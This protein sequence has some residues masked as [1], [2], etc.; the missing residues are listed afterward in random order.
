MFSIS[1]H[2]KKLLESF[3]SLSF[4]NVANSII[5]ILIF[6]YLIRVLG[7]SQ[8]GILMLINS[9]VIYS[10]TIVDYGFNLLGTS[11]ISKNRE[12]RYK[13]ENYISQV[14]YLKLILFLIVYICISIIL[15]IFS[16]DNKILFLISIPIV[17]GNVAFQTWVY[18]GFENMRFVAFLSLFLKVISAILVLIFIKNSNQIVYYPLINTLMSLI[19][20]VISFIYIN[21]RFGIRLVKINIYEICSLL[22]SGF[23]I[24]ISQIQIC[25]FNNT[26]ILILGLYGTPSQVG[27]F[28]AIEKIMRAL[29][30]LQGP[31]TGALFPHISNLIHIDRYKA[32]RFVLNVLKYGLLFYIII[33][34]IIIIAHEFVIKLFIGQSNPDA[35]HLLMVLISVPL[36]IFINNIMGTQIMINL[37]YKKEFMLILLV[38]GLTNLILCNILSYFYHEVGTAYS[39][40]IIEWFVALSM[41]IFVFKKRLLV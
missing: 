26:N 13:V 37:G 41:S 18:Q 35:Y 2:F 20:G 29:A 14:F 32:N 22:K 31:I 28:A 3:L 16:F 25:L 1:P 15:V 7:L 11:Y 24:F 38:S 6:P 27:L 5:P 36:S 30:M 19:F 4:I 12:F 21:K 23:Y 33:L 40:L 8:F 34:F 9:I 39:L 10:Q 17:L